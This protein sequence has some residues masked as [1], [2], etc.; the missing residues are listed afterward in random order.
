MAA[1]FTPEERV[2]V[3]QMMHDGV[4]K[5]Q[6]AKQLGRHR[7]SLF[8]E[9]GRNSIPHSY[10]RRARYCP[11][12]AQQKADQRR[13][14]P[15]T[16][17]MARPAIR[18]Y[19][20]KRMKEYWSPDQ[21]AGRMK[22]D[23][24][25]D[26]RLRISHQAIYTWIYTHDHRRCWERCLRRFRKRKRRRNKTPGSAAIANRPEVIERRER[27]GDW[28]GDT[29]VG[30][31]HSGALVSLV[32][33]KSGYLVLAKVSNLQSKT[34]QR[35]IQRRLKP[36]PP[37][38]RHSMTFDNGSEF[39][40]H[41]QLSRSLGI[42]IYFAEPSSPW[43]RGTNENTN[44]LARQ[45]HPKGSR[46]DEVSHQAVAHTETLLNNR[47]RKRHGYR[48]P[49]EVFHQPASDAMLA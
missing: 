39:A 4:S 16:K 5:A 24:A 15:R 19:V 11:V 30:A 35:S 3:S 48:T 1:H 46:L 44:G 47:P 8:R 34:V 10:G 33:R 27:L 29:I 37:E 12:T 49:S 17:K 45:F 31:G 40:R 22:L 6:I 13:H 9:L 26:P 7:S 18:E 25:S 20:E 21:I 14:Q 2:A 38:L 32:D 41:K 28:E 43:Q 42:E 36:L 23:F